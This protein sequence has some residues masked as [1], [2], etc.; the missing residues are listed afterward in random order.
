MAKI[1]T[2]RTDGRNWSVWQA[3]LERAVDELGI[4]AYISQT[5]PN[6]YDEQAN[7][8]A[9]EGVIIQA[10]EILTGGENACALWEGSVEMGLSAGT[11]IVGSAPWGVR[12]DVCDLLLPFSLPSLI[13]AQAYLSF[14]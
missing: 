11:I 6:P 7:A 4:G 3:N 1:P 14:S 9:K 8:L 13:Q 10:D 12:P 2:L 5:T